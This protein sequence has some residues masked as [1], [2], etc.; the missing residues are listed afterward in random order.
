MGCRSKATGQMSEENAWCLGLLEGM[1][2]TMEL[3]YGEVEVEVDTDV[4]A[5]VDVDGDVGVPKDIALGRPPGESESEQSVQERAR[6][7]DLNYIE[8]PTGIES[9]H[10]HSLLPQD[11]A[12]NLQDSVP[13]HGCES[14][15]QIF[16]T[17]TQDLTGANARAKTQEQS[18]NPT[19]E[20]TNVDIEVDVNVDADVEVEV[21]TVEDEAWILEQLG[22]KNLTFVLT[23]GDVEVELDVDVDV[24]VDVDVEVDVE[25]DVDDKNLTVKLTIQAVGCGGS[26]VLEVQ[27]DDVVGSLT[28]G[29]HKRWGV[30]PADQRLFHEGLLLPL[31][32]PIRYLDDGATVIMRRPVVLTMISDSF[33]DY[34]I[35]VLPGDDVESL[36]DDVQLRWGLRPSEQRL[37]ID[38]RPL[39][40]EAHL[41]SLGGGQIY[42]AKRAKDHVSKRGV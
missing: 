31:D 24:N 10:D 29:I 3:S 17:T 18:S 7:V 11:R 36:M 33:D 5:N 22:D 30:T 2:P 26:E 42:V 20:L 14:S 41:D 1:N 39:A 40:Q 37:F 9:I 6:E 35:E 27:G 34:D 23:N 38:G 28:M 12:A 21:D 32:T 19:V 25:V 16:P 13:V 4:E 15:A 8:G